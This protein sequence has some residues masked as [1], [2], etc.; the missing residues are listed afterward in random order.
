MIA[1]H[2]SP[3]RALWREAYRL[4]RLAP[5]EEGANLS[6]QDAYPWRIGF[7]ATLAAWTWKH[8]DPL[9]WGVTHRRLHYANGV[10]VDYVLHRFASPRL[11]K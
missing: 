6:W 5:C 2:H 11:P 3:V 1:N 10:S 9:K 4:A 8:G 7:G